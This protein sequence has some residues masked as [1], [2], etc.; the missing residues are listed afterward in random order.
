MCW[1]RPC[2]LLMPPPV[3]RAFSS[4]RYDHRLGL[5]P[6]QRRC[7]TLAQVPGLSLVSWWPCPTLIGRGL[8]WPWPL[9]CGGMRLQLWPDRQLQAHNLTL[10]PVQGERER[11]LTGSASECNLDWIY[12]KTLSASAT[13]DIIIN[14]HEINVDCWKSFKLFSDRINKLRFQMSCFVPVNILKDQKP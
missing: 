12:N 5:P 14:D 8:H 9:V 2:Q 7:I 3:C 10:H 6:R 11:D 4:R 13:H 1:L